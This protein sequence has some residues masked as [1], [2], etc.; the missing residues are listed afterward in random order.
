V[1]AAHYT[2]IRS[3]IA[4]RLTAV[5]VETVRF[6]PPERID[7]R[8]VRGPVPHVI[9]D[10]TLRDHHGGT[11]LTYHGE[12]GADLWQLG[13]WWSNLVARRWEAVVAKSLAAVKV[14]AE[15][16]TA[17]QRQPQHR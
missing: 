16:R 1:L 3:P 10:F 9:E 2:P 17:I 5:T 13:R 4:S 8:L 6:T 12:I 15:R 11:R 7:F 14:E